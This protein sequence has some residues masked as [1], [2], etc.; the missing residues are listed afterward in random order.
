MGLVTVVAGLLAVRRQSFV[1]AVIGLVGGFFTPYLLS[2]NEDH[3]I[4]LL[5]YVL[6]LDLGVLAVGRK[7]AWFSLPLLGLLGSATLYAGWAAQHLDGTKT[8][9]A[10][11]AAIVVACLFILGLGREA[12]GGEHKDLAATTSVLAITASF[13]LAFAVSGQSTFRAS[14]VV[15]VSYLLILTAGAFFVSRRIGAAPLVPA[16]AGF[17][18]GSLAWRVA[19]DAFPSQRAFTLALF[20]L[21]SIGFFLIWWLGHETKHTSSNRLG[22]SIALF[23]TYLVFL[24]VL[25]VEPHLEPVLPVWLFAA[26]HALL[27]LCVGAILFSGAWILAAQGYLFAVLL[28]LTSRFEQP[29]LPEYL[30]LIL[31]PMAVFW[32]LPF[33]S[34]RLRSDRLSWL[35]SAAAPVVHFPILYV[36]A[37]PSWGTDRLGAASVVF[38]ALALIALRRSMSVQSGDAEEKRFS[39]ALFGAVT[40]LFLTAAIPILLDKEWITVGWA[41]ESAALAWLA[42]R[43]REDGLAKASAA[44][45]GAAFVRLAVNPALWGYHPRGATPVFNWYLYTFGIPAAAFLL[46]AYW[47]NQ[48]EGARALR[49]PELLRLAAGI[50][51]FVLLNVEI[52]DFYSTGPHL[53]FR[54][55]GG[56]LAQDMT[57]SLAWGLFALG[58]LFLGITRSSKATRAAALAVL[59]LTIGKVF[60]HDLWDLGALY[61]VGSIV[62]LAVALLAVSFLTQ[63][64]VFPRNRP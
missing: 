62:G 25:D 54:L 11:I 17:T 30:P 44:L 51:F 64:F 1:L 61:R 47:L 6:L 42:I 41:L 37:K 43:I 33:L 10:L 15:L 7:R 52:A 13:L 48:S 8:P 3:P 16:A 26:A 55:S 19:S 29:R 21:P 34:P 23:G 39:T 9:Y 14:P 22:A 20:T 56:G 31:I 58:L 18:V 32:A 36:L 12:E 53:D 24:R 46:S 60:L 63:R 5:A 28:A 2:T 45:A 38:G 4:G 50:V 35:S 59:L 49:L 27:V 40:L 57:Y